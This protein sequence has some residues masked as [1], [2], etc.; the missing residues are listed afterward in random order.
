MV[1]II[2][3][4]FRRYKKGALNNEDSEV[5]KYTRRESTRKMALELDEL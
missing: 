4:Y 5:M 2:L 3:N 1:R